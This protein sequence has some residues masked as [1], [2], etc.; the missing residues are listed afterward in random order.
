MRPLQAID[1][2]QSVVLLR[3]P[4]SM[5]LSL[6]RGMFRTLIAIGIAGLAMLIAGTW[7]LA[8]GITQPLSTLEAAA[9]NLREGVYETVAIKTKDELARLAESFNT[10]TD[11]IRERE[12]RITQLAYHDAETRLPN[13]A[14]LERRL[15]AATQPK[16]LYLAAIGVDRF[17]HVRG[18]I[19]YAH[20]AALI[21]R[22]GGRLARLAP[23]APMA[24]LSS[25]VLGVAFLA[26]ER[27][28][29]PKARGRA[30]RQPRTTAF[31]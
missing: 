22:L 13:R 12:R 8:R 14:A 26:D 25:D 19:G 18:A 30:D 17:A 15:A 31:P 3:Y 10:M 23:N 20:A 6:Y 16:R 27:G 28:R 7:F 4:L 5:A 24:R 21:R 2:T 9:R 11:A 29:R 1:G